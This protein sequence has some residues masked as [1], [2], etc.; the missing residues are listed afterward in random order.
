M[1]TDVQSQ[2]IEDGDVS[3]TVI[4]VARIVGLLID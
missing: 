2:G 4:Q 1:T 3:A